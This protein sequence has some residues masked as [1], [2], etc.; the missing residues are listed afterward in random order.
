M[1]TQ[2]Y[3]ISTA[4]SGDFLTFEYHLKR[5]FYM[6]YHTVHPLHRIY[7][8]C[9]RF[10][11]MVEDNGKIHLQGECLYL[12]GDFRPCTAAEK[13]FLLKRLWKEGLV[14][15]SAKTRLRKTNILERMYMFLRHTF[16]NDK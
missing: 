5:K 13:S 14:W 8:D 11:V 16:S 3:D 15:E 7:K 1:N 6:I 12:E 9:Y 2:N 4:Q 10:F